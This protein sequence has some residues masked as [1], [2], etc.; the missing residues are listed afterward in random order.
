MLAGNSADTTI[1][2]VLGAASYQRGDYAR[3]VAILR[4]A[5]EVRPGYLDARF[6]LGLALAALGLPDQAA[7]QFTAVLDARADDVESL[8]NRGKALFDQ[9]FAELALQDFDAA[10][11]MS[12][13]HPQILALRGL[14]VAQLRR[15]SDA[16]R[17]QR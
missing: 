16:N 12:P 10:L 6:N 13:D 15:Q 1:L 8:A 5:V 9:G 2:N 4:R 17:S 7:R 3:A 11:A 14:A